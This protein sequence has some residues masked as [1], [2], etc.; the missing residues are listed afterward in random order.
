MLQRLRDTICTSC[1][2]D[3]SRPTI[4]HCMQVY[5]H[6]HKIYRQTDTHT[7]TSTHTQIKIDVISKN[8]YHLYNISFYNNCK[9]F[10]L[11]LM[12]YV[13]A[14]IYDLCITTLLYLHSAY[15]RI[16]ILMFDMRMDAHVHIRLLRLLLLLLLPLRLLI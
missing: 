13:L 11:L 4:Y 8:M 2:N 14:C 3:H 10:L 12:L 1:I 6:M 16:A 7:H 15:H 9:F 5:M